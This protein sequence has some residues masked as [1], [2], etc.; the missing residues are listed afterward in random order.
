MPIFKDL[1]TNLVDGVLSGADGPLG[2]LFGDKHQSTSLSFPADVEGVGQRHFVQF[3]IV[4]RDGAA[5]GVDGKNTE[6]ATSAAGGVL[7]GVVGAAIGGGIGGGL[8]GAAV[9]GIL[10]ETGIGG[11]LDD[12]IQGAQDLVASGIDT[13]VGG[14]TAGVEST[15]GKLSESA[16]SFKEAVV[17]KVPIAED[18]LSGIGS[19][20]GSIGGIA[21][22]FSDSLGGTEKTEGDIVL[23]LPFGVNET[24]QANWTGGEMGMVGAAIQT[25]GGGLDAVKQQLSMSNL[26]GAA[27]EIG[28]DIAG[29]VL[30]ND[31]IKK[32]L[33]KMQGKSVNPHWELFFEGVQPRTFT[34]D[35]K[36]SP[37]NQT[38]A[39]TIKNIIRLF[40]MY[41]APASSVDGSARYWGYPSLFQIQYW[42]SEKLHRIKPCALQNITV[43][44]T[45][46][47]D[48]HTF[49]DGHPIQTDMTLT[50]MESELLTRSDFTEQEGY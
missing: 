17:E 10:E 14:I 15:F 12:A 26:K 5:F 32:K 22:G 42:N 37:R 30:G 43:N 34:F 29:Q 4:T 18:A 23:Y 19:F 25:A 20:A 21:E 31:N 7:G 9:S 35:F 46:S 11:A 38:E 40:Q 33:L 24:Y 16:A 6:E 2:S 49:Y 3:T 44:Y 48:N 41:S 50:F 8:A 45:G 39:E 13:A 47:G 28:G 1:G 36:M 27:A